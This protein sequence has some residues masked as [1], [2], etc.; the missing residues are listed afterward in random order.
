MAFDLTDLKVGRN[1]YILNR[2]PVLNEGEKIKGP[3]WKIPDDSFGNHYISA[4]WGKNRGEIIGGCLKIQE[5][6][7]RFLKN[8]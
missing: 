6:S 2:V 5:L 1:T 8:L 4:R 3:L 7:N